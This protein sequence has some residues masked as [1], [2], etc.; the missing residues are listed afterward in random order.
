MNERINERINE[1]FLKVCFI[2]FETLKLLTL[3]N[4]DFNKIIYRQNYI[5]LSVRVRVKYLCQL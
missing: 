4:I 1:R 5:L 3:R 2:V